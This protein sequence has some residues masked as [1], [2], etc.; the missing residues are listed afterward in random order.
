MIEAIGLTKSFNGK[1]IIDN[2]DISV[3]EGD[4]FGFLGPNGA[5]KTTTIRMLLKLIHPDRGII[6]LGG[7]DIKENFS[8]VVE[9]VG[10][11]V[12]TPKFYS[13]LSGRKNLELMANLI[14]LS[15]M[16]R[17]DEVLELVELNDRVKDKV[18]TYSLG[19]KQRLG[20]ANA[21][22]MI[23]DSLYLMNPQMELILRV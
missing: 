11:I 14:G 18:G 1:T 22:L 21:L 17:V 5:G 6:R 16:D 13:Y 3:D 8:F 23:L 19:M 9:M 10:A 4:I 15:S 2:I 12:E 7:S 20:I